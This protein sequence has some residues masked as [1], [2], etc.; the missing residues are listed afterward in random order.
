M[1]EV[2]SKRQTERQGREGGER[3]RR[4]DIELN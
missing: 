2:E 1:K 4:E 3:E